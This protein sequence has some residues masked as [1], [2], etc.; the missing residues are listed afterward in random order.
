MAA[1]IKGKGKAAQP[2]IAAIKG[3]IDA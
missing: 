2:H 3:F 1:E